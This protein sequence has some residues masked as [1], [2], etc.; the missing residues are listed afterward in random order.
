M[1]QS[2]TSLIAQI[3]GNIVELQME[4]ARA[5]QV[6]GKT[7]AHPE[8]RR[9]LAQIQDARKSLAQELELEVGALAVEQMV[10]EAEV[11]GLEQE[12]R[13]LHATI[14]KFPVGSVEYAR[15][16]AEVARLSEPRGV[17]YKAWERAAIREKASYQAFEILDPAVPPPK[18]SSPS[19]LL[20]ALATAF[21]VGLI[22]LLIAA[23][24]ERIVPSQPQPDSE[25]S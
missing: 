13:R 21:C 19:P 14:E 18:K 2:Q 8:V 15:R 17:L 20:N 24:Q 10:A 4:L 6:E 23:R 11:G 3:K 16:K 9:L 5:Q 12:R 1:V 25:A 7:A 22:T